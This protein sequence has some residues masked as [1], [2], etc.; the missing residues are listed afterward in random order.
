LTRR[1]RAIDIPRVQRLACFA[2]L[3]GL[4]SVSSARAGETVA[5]MQNWFGPYFTVSAP[6]AGKTTA[7][8]LDEDSQWNV[9]HKPVQGK[10][11]RIVWE[12]RG[13]RDYCTFIEAAG[14]TGGKRDYIYRR[15]EAGKTSFLGH[16]KRYRGNALTFED[17]KGTSY[18]MITD[19]ATDMS[20][21]PKDSYAI[22]MVRIYYVRKGSEYRVVKFDVL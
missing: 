19:N 12:K 16:I 14:V 7:F 10:P 5:E 18:A 3:V 15:S 9:D 20:G 17:L 2:L 4:L 13:E 8:Y 22:P 1:R 11:V 6:P 21:F